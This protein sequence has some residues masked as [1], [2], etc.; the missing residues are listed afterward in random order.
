[1]KLVHWSNK[2]K[3]VIKSKCV[4]TDMENLRWTQGAEDQQ[5]WAE[6]QIGQQS[7]KI[8]EIVVSI[9]G[10]FTT[11]IV[12]FMRGPVGCK[13]TAIWNMSLAV[14]YLKTEHVSDL[15]LYFQLLAVPSIPQVLKN[16]YCLGVTSIQFSSVTQSC[17]TLFDPMDCSML[18]FP[19][20][21]HLPEPAQ[22]QVC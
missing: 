1:M 2:S 16:I 17:L 11:M 21:H 10:Y 4:D 3:W 15:S 8:S 14:S 5:N 19:V 12:K 22:T 9:F 7:E 18:G 20:H 6:R 13:N